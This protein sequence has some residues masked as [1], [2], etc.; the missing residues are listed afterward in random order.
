MRK[1]LAMGSV[2][3]LLAITLFQGNAVAQN[4]NIVAKIGD[5]QITLSDFN[6]IID[7]LDTEKQKALVKNP[8]L[9]ETFLR[10]V[11]QSMV[12][13]DIA[14]KEGFDKKSEVKKQLELFTD[15]FLVNE[16]L[17]REIV[18]KIT[19]SEDEM[20]SYY[21]SHKN[22]FKTPEMVRTRHIL[23]EATPLSSDE[24]KKKAREKA[25][26]ILKRIKDGEDFAKLA[27][28]FSDDRG[29]KQKGGDLGLFPRGAMVKP[30]E[31]AAFALKPGEISGIVETQFGYHIIK[32]EERKDSSVEPF[33]AVMERI[34]QKLLQESIK[35]KVTEFIEKAM[36]D[37]KVE[38]YPEVLSGA[39]K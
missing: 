1:F 28:D 11:V 16:F 33:E 26:G 34:N 24:E 36:K 5:K 9:K 38:I 19:V 13:S 25:E 7:Y 31:D 12:I 10:Q 3:L 27:S 8:Q 15:N 2:L 37:A 18:Q 23:I 32:V 22:E 17:R 30:F 21:D 39:K 35:S 14:K 6:T 29:S 4:D 20:K